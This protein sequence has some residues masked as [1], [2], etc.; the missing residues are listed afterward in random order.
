MSQSLVAQVAQDATL[1]PGAGV[2]RAVGDHG[3]GRHAH[4]A[5]GVTAYVPGA[6]CHQVGLQH[7]AA[8]LGIVVNDG[9]DQGAHLL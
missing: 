8:I 5:H 7:T 1:P 3:E 2:D 6:L 4:A 9:L